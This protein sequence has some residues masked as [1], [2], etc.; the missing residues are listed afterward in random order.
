MFS[1]FFFKSSYF[2]A[3]V[4]KIRRRVFVFCGNEFFSTSE[5]LCQS[6]HEYYNS[7]IFKLSP[8]NDKQKRHITDVTF[9]NSSDISDM[10][11]TSTLHRGLLI[12]NDL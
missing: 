4:I 3:G 12:L 1:D 5:N 11:K 7:L 9:R 10:R 6:L 2:C 8:C